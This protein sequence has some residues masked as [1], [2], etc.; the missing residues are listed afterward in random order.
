MET[1]CL[2]TFAAPLRIAAETPKEANSDDR[3][4]LGSTSDRQVTPF[5]IS[6]ERVYDC[7]GADKFASRLTVTGRVREVDAFRCSHSGCNAVRRCMQVGHRQS[8]SGTSLV[9][10]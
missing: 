3:A 4:Y 8:M 2:S 10:P 1:H 6:S 7:F 5:S 9:L